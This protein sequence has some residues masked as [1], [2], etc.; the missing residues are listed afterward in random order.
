M[1]ELYI[2]KSDN[3]LNIYAK[4]RYN[5]CGE[6]YE[7][8][9]Q[10]VININEI[11]NIV[12][13]PGNILIRTHTC[14]TID[15]HFYITKQNKEITI[16]VPFNKVKEHRMVNKIIV[17]IMNGKLV[18]EANLLP[19][20]A[21]AKVTVPPRASVTPPPAV[22]KKKRINE[23]KDKP[24]SRP[25]PSASAPQGL[26]EQTDTERAETTEPTAPSLPISRQN[27]VLALPDITK[28][29]MV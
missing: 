1:S 12:V 28:N 4:S 23:S 8:E 18:N 25:P 24:Q 5:V 9:Y 27:S 16:K 7:I 14:I 3:F 6:K 19:I 22:E 20:K 17:D 10:N 21:K 26:S 2:S 29:S 11:K 15:I 13:K